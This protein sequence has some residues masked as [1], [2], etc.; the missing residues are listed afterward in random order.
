MYSRVRKHANVGGSTVVVRDRVTRLYFIIIL[1]S[2][3]IT[4]AAV[5]GGKFN[6]EPTEG[7]SE[8]ELL[9]ASIKIEVYRQME[10]GK[11][12]VTE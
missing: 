4:L 5:D 9:V 7:P 10:G 3:R 6:I 1:V 8:G 2:P 11:T 12:S